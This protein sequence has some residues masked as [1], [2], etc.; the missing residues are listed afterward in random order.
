[1]DLNEFKKRSNDT[2]YPEIDIVRKDPVTA[3]AVSKLEL[4]TMPSTRD[5]NG[6]RAT[7]IDMYSISNVLNKRGQKNTDSAAITNLLPDINLAKQI[8]ISSILSPKDMTSTDLIYTGARGVFSPELASSILSRIERYLDEEY[9][10]KTKLS[11]ILSEC[12]FEKGSYPV[13]VIP[14]NAIDAF[15]NGTKSF[16]NEELN[17]TLSNFVSNDKFKNIGILGDPL[18]EEPKKGLSLE[19]FN[20]PRSYSDIKQNIVLKED[21]KTIP[22]EDL[23]VLDN[24]SVLKFPNI[25]KVLIS[26]ETQRLYSEHSLSMESLN[27]LSNIQ[28]EKLLFRRRNTVASTVSSLPN[29]ANTNRKSIGKPLVMKI[30]SE[31]VLPVHVPGNVEEHVGYFVLLDQNGNP[32]ET[33]DGEHNWNQYKDTKENSF[34]STMIKRVNTNLGNSNSFDFNNNQH[35]NVMTKVYSDIIETDLLNRLKNGVYNSDLKIGKNEEIYRIMLA[36][37]LS[38]KMTQILFIPLEYMTY[39]AFDYDDD[40]VGRS[41]LDA[42]MTINTL[43]S[44]ML[45]TDV[46]GSMKNSIGRTKVAAVLP[47]NDPNVHKTIEQIVDSIVKSRTIQMPMGVTNP[48]DIFEFVQRSGYEWEFSGHPGI[49][50][51]KLSFDQI[52]SNYQKVDNELQEGLRR[53][54]LSTMG[55]TPEM[56]DKGFSADFATTV[57]QDNILFSKRVIT[58]QDQ[59]VPQLSDHIRKICLNSGSLVDEL[60]NLIVENKSGIKAKLEDLIDGDVTGVEKEVQDKILVNKTLEDFLCSIVVSLPKP[61]SVTLENQANELKTYTELLDDVLNAYISEEYFVSETVGDVS[62]YIPSIKALIKSHYIRRYCAEKG[63]MTEIAELVNIGED[64]KPLFN[65][66]EITQQHIEGLSAS[67]VTT[68]NT[69]KRIID[70]NNKKLVPGEATDPDTDPNMDDPDNG[71]PSATD[72]SSIDDLGDLGVDEPDTQDDSNKD[73]ES[74]IKNKNKVNLDDDGL[75]EEE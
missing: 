17:K 20:K 71:D 38:K 39:I 52:Q 6:N 60:R 30:P 73:D 50:E 22:I 70:K 24:P 41:L 59:F 32:I 28:A 62:S 26:R 49:P 1:M 44:I 33:P 36:R 15:I 11:K 47:Q 7:N 58:I 14:E 2:K 57:I 31:A 54:S 25:S 16:S 55:V 74:K 18:K 40:G 48:N 29:Q 68:M 4:S 43:R 3:A 13:A 42:T 45:F 63:I 64:G 23:V 65:L 56:V 21:N 19:H 8:L 34:A 12:L 51:L 61:T 66:E 75:P 72:D 10:I 46:M 67:S 27:D 53:S 9:N 35:V 37:T 69:I 5:S